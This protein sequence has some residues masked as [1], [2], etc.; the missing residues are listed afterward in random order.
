[1]NAKH[2]HGFTI[3]ELLIGMIAASIL[4]LAAGGLLSNTYRGWVRSL[5]LA[6]LEREAMV[7]VAAINYAVRSAS[8][9]GLV[10]GTDMLTVSGTVVHAFSVS[11]SN[12]V[13]NNDY[14]N[15]IVKNHQG[16]FESAFFPAPT[17]VVRV[18]MEFSDPQNA[19]TMTISNM[20]IRLRN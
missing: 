15:P 8:T 1:M 11:S 19:V 7:A 2:Q 4:A 5:A 16:K 20:F 17:P 12:L 13:D 9:N 14:S 18:T 10:T 6:N 3:V